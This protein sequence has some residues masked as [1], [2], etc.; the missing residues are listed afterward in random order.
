MPQAVECDTNLELGGPCIPELRSP[1][2]GTDRSHCLEPH[3]SERP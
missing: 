3:L 1:L 2:N